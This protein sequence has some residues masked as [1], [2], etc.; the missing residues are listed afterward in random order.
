MMTRK[1]SRKE[2]YGDICHKHNDDDQ[3]SKRGRREQKRRRLNKKRNKQKK[4]KN[5]KKKLNWFYNSMAYERQ[6]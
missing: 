1:R 5:K 6:T 2:K 4:S 3:W